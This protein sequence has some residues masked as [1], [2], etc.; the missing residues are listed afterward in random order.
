[1]GGGAG[2]LG[3]AALHADRTGHH[4]FRHAHAD[5]A[6][7]GDG[8]LLVHAGA[9]VAGMTLDID[10]QRGIHADGQVVLA[11]RVGDHPFTV[12]QLADLLMQGL[13][14]IAHGA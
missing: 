14:E 3:G 1:M 7:H 6:V 11:V 13:V 9:V 10:G 2:G 4:V 5:V 12:V 8:G